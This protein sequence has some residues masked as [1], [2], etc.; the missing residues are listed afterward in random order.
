M[1]AALG[2]DGVELV[3]EDDAGP[4]VARTLEDAPYV[5]L[6]L[7]DVHVKQLRALDGEEIERARRRNCFGEQCLSSARRPIK[8]DTWR[9][10][11]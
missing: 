11:P 9:M 7:A 8:Q 4:R 2:R 1:R 3:E 5:R 10:P 6:G